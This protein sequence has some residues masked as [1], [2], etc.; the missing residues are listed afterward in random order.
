MEC[1]E[2][3]FFL[4]INIGYE[5]SLYIIVCIFQNVTYIIMIK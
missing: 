3:R 2:F 4:I 5:M 1:S